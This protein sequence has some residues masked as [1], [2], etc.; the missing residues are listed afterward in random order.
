MG[1]RAASSALNGVERSG[2]GNHPK[3]HENEQEAGLSGAG[4]QAIEDG[5]V[6][7]GRGKM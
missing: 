3:A 1:A 4:V 7:R 6:S 5:S 2:S